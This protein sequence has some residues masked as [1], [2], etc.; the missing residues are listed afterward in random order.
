MGQ[1]LVAGSV[2]ILAAVV[3]FQ[4]CTRADFSANPLQ[5]QRTAQSS[6]DLADSGNGRPYSGKVYAFRDGSC[7]DSAATARIE[8]AADGSAWLTHDNCQPMTPPASLA[9]NE[10]SFGANGETLTYRNQ[11]FLYVPQS[12]GAPSLNQKSTKAVSSAATVVSSPFA[13][14]PTAGDTVV[15]FVLLK[16]TGSGAAVTFTITD[17]NGNAYASACDSAGPVSGAPGD[18]LVG[19]L[20]YAK[21][22]SV[23]QASFAV[24]LAASASSQITLIAASVSGLD[25]HFPLDQAAAGTGQSYNPM[26]PWT[27]TTSTAQQFVA[28]LFVTSGGMGGIFNRDPDQLVLEENSC[29]GAGP[30]GSTDYKIQTSSQPQRGYWAHDGGDYDYR[31]CVATFK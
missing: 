19:Q 24:T 20:F 22:V 3:A 15:V 14:L 6:E 5:F 18:Y 27:A 17:N 2:C 25:P 13:T 9:S 16:S 26:T 8:I 11:T 23:N 29:C 4:N 28:S 31:A 1:R 12:T 21:N 10:F 30:Y 7:A